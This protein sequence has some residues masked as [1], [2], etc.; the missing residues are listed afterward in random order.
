MNLDL[1]FGADGFGV[2]D[3]ITA[4]L[5]LLSALMC[6]AAGIG[7]LRFPDVLSRLHAATKPQILGL[8][9]IVADVAVTNPSVGTVTLAVAIVFFQGLTAPA[10]AHMAGRAAYR[11]GHFLSDTLLVDEF[12]RVEKPADGPDLDT[13]GAADAPDGA[14]A[15]EA[16]DSTAELGDDS[17]SPADDLE[18]R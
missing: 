1:G 7:L 6:F 3:V 2:R 8:I 13:P 14:E 5:V 15:A 16:A 11:T 18:R 9:A 17:D 4:L 12:A 10:S